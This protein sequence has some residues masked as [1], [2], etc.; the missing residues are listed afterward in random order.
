M[1]CFIC[2]GGPQSKK[3]LKAEMPIWW[4]EACN[5][6]YFPPILDTN[7]CS[8]YVEGGIDSCQGD[9][10][11]PLLIKRNRKVRMPSLLWSAY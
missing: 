10:G 7:I 8:G 11:G 3:L 4:N 9:S 5:E 2:L 6:A 1:D